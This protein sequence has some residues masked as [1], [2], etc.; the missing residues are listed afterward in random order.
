MSAE[1]VASW[2]S[3]KAHLENFAQVFVQHHIT[4][5]VLP[6]LTRHDLIYELGMTCIST[7]KHFQIALEALRPDSPARVHVSTERQ[8]R[9]KSHMALPFGRVSCMTVAAGESASDAPIIEEA[10]GDVIIGS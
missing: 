8:T 6:L 10:G 9:M 3:S 1:D 4:G 2:L 5:W 7:R